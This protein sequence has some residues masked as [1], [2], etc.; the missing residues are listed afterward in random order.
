MV[1][2]E[3]VIINNIHEGTYA[4]LFMPRWFRKVHCLVGL[5]AVASKASFPTCQRPLGP[6]IL[7]GCYATSIEVNYRSDTCP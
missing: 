5:S 4:P 6:L 1:D 2:P 7:Q 3:S